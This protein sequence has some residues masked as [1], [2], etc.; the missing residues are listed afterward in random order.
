MLEAF[1]EG[2]GVWKCSVEGCGIHDGGGDF[3]NPSD[4]NHY[5]NPLSNG[6]YE[7]HGWG[8]GV[9][10]IIGNFKEGVQNERVEMVRQ[11][12]G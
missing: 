7:H 12:G 2:R 5:E 11:D 1:A 4:H 10:G 3:L 8:G 6:G 9:F